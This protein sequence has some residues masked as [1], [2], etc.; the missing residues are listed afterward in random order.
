MRNCDRNENMHGDKKHDPTDT[1]ENGVL[2]GVCVEKKREWKPKLQDNNRGGRR[3]K[4]GLDPHGRQT[5]N[6]LP[7]SFRHRWIIPR[8]LCIFL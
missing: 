5:V 8:S 2:C 1:K 3:S 6:S 4:W 7:K